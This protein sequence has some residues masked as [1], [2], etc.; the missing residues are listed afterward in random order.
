MSGIDRMRKAQQLLQKRQLG[1]ATVAKPPSSWCTK[2]KSEK[3]VCAKE[4][5][6]PI[7]VVVL[8]PPKRVQEEKKPKKPKK[9]RGP[10]ALKSRLP[11]GSTFFVT[12]NAA[13]KYWRGT[14]TVNGVAFEA[15]RAG[16]RGV[17]D[18]L[19]KMYHGKV[20]ADIEETIK[21]LVATASERE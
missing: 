2:C 9:P 20:V 17:T 21:D 8:G 1:Q 5:T 6:P 18:T 13:G 15:A 19:D 4:P 3:C 11:D 10:D 16:L 7:P 14:L 12:Y